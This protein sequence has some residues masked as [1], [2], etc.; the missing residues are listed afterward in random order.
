MRRGQ[1]HDVASAAGCGAGGLDGPTDRPTPDATPSPASTAAMGL[2]I[3]STLAAT[4][5]QDRARVAA[6]GAERLLLAVAHEVGWVAA[7][8]IAYRSADVLGG[9]RR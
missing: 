8:E 2:A 1:E 5:P 6:W 3:R 4:A 7:A 9:V